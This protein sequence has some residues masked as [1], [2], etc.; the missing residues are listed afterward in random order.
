MRIFCLL[1]RGLLHAAWMFTLG[2]CSANA[3]PG[4]PRLLV[5]LVVDGLPMRQVTGYRDQLAPDG[6][7]R[8]FS[9]GAVFANAHYGHGYTVTAAGHATMLTGAYPHRSGIIGNEWRDPDTGASVYCTQD[10]AHTYLGHTTPPS[11]GTSP[12]NLRAETVGDVLRRSS[13]ESKVI[14]VSGKD[15]GAIL[16]AG[17]GG[18][19]YI[20]MTES[21]QFASS[22]YYMQN[23][24]RWVN[25]FNAAKPA[26]AYFKKTWAALLPEEAYQRSAPDGQRWQ[27]ADGNAN[28]LPTVIGEGS[29][30]PGPRFYSNLI[31]TPFSDILTLDFARA[32]IDGEALGRGP[33]TDILS[34]SL[35]GHDYVNHAMGPES[36]ISH[37]HFLHLDR[38]LQAFF[39]DLDARIGKDQYVAVLTAD[40]GFAD[41][42]EWA[43]S[44]GR[45][46]GRLNPGGTLAHLNAGL[47]E[48]F[49]DA[50]WAIGFSAAGILL[51]A[52]VMAAKG[53]A[54]ATVEA[55]AKALLLQ[56]GGIADVFTR[57]QLADAAPTHTPYLAASRQ[58]WFSERSPQL[59]VVLSPGWTLSGLRIGSTHGSP[60]AYDTHVPILF[61]GPR[62]VDPVQVDDRVEV[63]DI[64]NTLAGLLGIAPPAQSQGR[65]LPLVRNGKKA[66]RSG[67]K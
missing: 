32:A 55:E 19:A 65:P 18:V 9:R 4:S 48:Q 23:H 57:E 25:A 11:S 44:Q 45:A 26:D 6:F 28:R 58:A 59:H 12:K 67:A 20:Y 43:Q 16:P 8:F 53:V 17:R 14:A 34:I 61:Y 30:A 66:P 10:G 35:S 36:R 27:R 31:G 7:N 63:A 60:H 50:K 47:S 1:R 42:P 46:A 56:V 49:G 54:S 21:G 39:A 2:L 62:W 13:P 41:T 51:D 37:D 5:F 24:P 40:H 64:A 15:R 3:S 29:D 38:T 22:T 33:H 52:R